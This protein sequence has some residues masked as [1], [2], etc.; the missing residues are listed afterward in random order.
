ML[1]SVWQLDT[2]KYILDSASFWCAMSDDLS[3]KSDNRIVNN[4]LQPYDRQEQL[5]FRELKK[6][7][8]CVLLHVVKASRGESAHARIYKNF[9]LHFKY[10]LPASG[11]A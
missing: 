2:L 9:S 7:K 1:T 8:V 3:V 6:K 4:I 5:T 10:P 11:Q